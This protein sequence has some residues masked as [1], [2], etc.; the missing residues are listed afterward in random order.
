MQPG[1]PKLPHYPQPYRAHGMT[2]DGFADSQDPHLDQEQGSFSFSLLYTR[3]MVFLVK[4]LFMKGG[5]IC[6][7]SPYPDYL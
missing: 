2:W 7:Y 5:D 4:P 6:F 1:A 3:K